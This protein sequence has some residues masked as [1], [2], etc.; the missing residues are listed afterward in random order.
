MAHSAAHKKAISAGLKRY[1]A[2]KWKAEKTA[3]QPRKIS[4][5]VNRQLKRTAKVINKASTF[6]EKKVRCATNPKKWIAE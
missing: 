3:K 4:K 6:I 1:H 5:A 2:A